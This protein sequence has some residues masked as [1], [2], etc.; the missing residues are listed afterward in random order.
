MIVGEALG[1]WLADSKSQSETV[2]SIGDFDRCLRESELM[3][4]FRRELESSVDPDDLLDMASRFLDRIADIE[5]LIEDMIRAALA[6]PFYRPPMRRVVSPVHS[7]LMLVDSDRLS[8]MLAV[9]TPDTLA[10]K[11]TSQTGPASITFG[12]RQSLFRFIKSG[13]ATLSFWEAPTIEPGFT[14]DKSG[15]CQLIERRK[16]VDGETVMLDGRSQSFIIDHAVADIVYFQADTP[17]GAAPLSVEYDSNSLAFAGASSTDEASSRMQMIV[18]LLRVMDRSDA[19]PLLRDV[20]GNRHFYVRWHAMRE[21]LALDAQAA[22]PPLRLMARSDPHP[23]VRAAAAYT[24]EAFFGAG[25]GIDEEDA[26]LC[27]A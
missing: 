3:V 24:L 21:L 1:R 22:L 27:P 26:G 9:S 17:I 6:N 13:D 20:L 14:G 19:V 11:R 10:A 8:I 7:G 16:I 4:S 23:E 15:R 5:T 2:S 12:G 18:S 25:E